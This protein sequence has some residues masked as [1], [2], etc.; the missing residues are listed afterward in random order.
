MHPLKTM[1]VGNYPIGIGVDEKAGQT[2][3]VN[4]RE[5]TLSVID[6]TPLEVRRTRHIPSN[7]SNIALNI[8]G[9]LLYLALKSEDRV[10]L[11]R[12]RDL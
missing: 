4:N 11:V 7:V 9:G 10:A 8:P 2:Y 5:N 3:I 12:L 1:R 6:E